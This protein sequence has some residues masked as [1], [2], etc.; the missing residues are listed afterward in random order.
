ML[1][2]LPWLTSALQQTEN[3]A[4]ALPAPIL[5]LIGGL[6]LIVMTLPG[7]SMR[8]RGGEKLERKL[9]NIIEPQQ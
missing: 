8:Q 4:N 6:A 1:V 2:G 3:Y 5:L 9:W 7:L